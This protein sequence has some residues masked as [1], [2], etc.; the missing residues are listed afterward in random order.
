MAAHEQLSEA[1]LRHPNAEFEL[2]GAEVRIIWIYGAGSFGRDVALAINALGLK[3]AGFIE[4][5]PRDTVAWGYPIHALNDSIFDLNNDQVFVAVFNRGHPLFQI[6]KDLDARGFRQ[7]LMPWNYYGQLVDT[8]GWRYWLESSAFIGRHWDQLEAAKS[9]MADPTSRQCL[10]DVAAFRSGAYLEYSMLRHALPQYFNELTLPQLPTVVNYVDG[11][12]FDGDT[13]QTL[14]RQ[15]HV[16]Q[17]WLF[18]PEASNFSTLRHHQTGKPCDSVHLMP[19]A[20]SDRHERLAFTEG[21]GEASCVTAAGTA[22]IS[23]V[24]LDDV[25]GNSPVNLI[26]LDIEGGEHAALLGA[27][28]TIARNAPVLALSAYH[29]P[30]DL[31]DLIQL[32]DGFDCG[33]SYWLRQHQ[34]NSFDLVLYAVRESRV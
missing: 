9:R 12:A 4:Q 32:I 22:G 7:V 1:I 17:A 8:L 23:A 25:V 34:F 29:R 18:E 21:V 5:S 10:T 6:H 16:G 33:Y 14:A 27:Q 15:V 20:L 28:R 31:W 24:A 13:F 26:K 2:E 30:E 3:V 19:L 11:G